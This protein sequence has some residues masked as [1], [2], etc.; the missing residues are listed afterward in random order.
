MLSD[1][2]HTVR[3]HFQIL[4]R[5]EKSQCERNTD[6]QKINPDWNA[7]AYLL[8]K[9]THTVEKKTWL[10]FPGRSVLTNRYKR[11][12]S[13]V[14]LKQKQKNNTGECTEEQNEICGFLMQHKHLHTLCEPICYPS[15]VLRAGLAGRDLYWSGFYSQ[16]NQKNIVTVKSLLADPSL[17]HWNW[18]PLI[19]PVNQTTSLKHTQVRMFMFDREHVVKFLC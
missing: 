8:P 12:W 17:A 15:V 4:I 6:P 3:I 1:S 19:L 10:F 16:K 9:N 5:K 2:Q 13:T 7:T 14:K 11:S 18:L